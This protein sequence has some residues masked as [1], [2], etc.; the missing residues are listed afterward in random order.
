M[1]VRSVF[2]NIPRAIGL[3]LVAAVLPLVAATPAMAQEEECTDW[4]AVTDEAQDYIG[5]GS[6]YIQLEAHTCSDGQATQRYVR[7]AVHQV[8]VPD[9]V[10]RM[11]VRV[12]RHNGCVGCEAHFDSGELA[13]P[14]VGATYYSDAVPITPGVEWG[15][16]LDAHQVDAPDASS[17]LN[18]V[19][20]WRPA[21]AD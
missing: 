17:V 19:T 20:R 4:E 1:R 9:E 2:R 7:A 11:R 8:A 16:I 5:D 13:L 14:G 12:Y 18:A 21:A 15:G 6:L 10:D 3:V